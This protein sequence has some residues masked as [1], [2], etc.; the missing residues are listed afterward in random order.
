MSNPF[1]V[2]IH[3]TII[4]TVTLILC[5]FSPLSSG[6]GLRHGLV[7]GLETA[8]GAAKPHHAGVRKS[9]VRE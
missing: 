3:D 2:V 5:V 4:T 7:R 9:V 6:I 1:S 8:F